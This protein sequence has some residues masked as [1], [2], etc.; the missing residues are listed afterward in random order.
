MTCKDCIHYDVCEWEQKYF[1]NCGINKSIAEIA[2]KIA[3]QRS[4]K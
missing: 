4:D 2:N 1:V 3:I